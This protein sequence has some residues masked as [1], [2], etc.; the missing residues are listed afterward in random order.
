MD[1]KLSV[2]I[3]VYNVE[4]FLK[5]CLDSI[6]KQKIDGIEIILIDDGSSDNSA[7]LCK[8]Y[9]KEYSN[10]KFFSKKNGGASS[11]RNYGIPKASGEYIW[12]IDS[13]DK[14]ENNSIKQII[15][16]MNEFK[17]D[18]IICNSKKVYEDGEMIDECIYTIPKGEYTSHEF[19]DVLKGNPKSV[20]FAPQ[21]YI[22]KRSFI[23][24]NKF[25]F[26]EGIIHED[27]LWI[28]QLLI[29]AKNIFYSNLNIYYHYMWDGSVMHSTKIEKSGLSCYVVATNLLK[30]FDDSK[31][32]DLQ[33]LRDKNVNTYLQAVWKKSD[34][35][36]SN[37][38]N[39]IIPLKNAYY[40]KTKVKALLYF[41]SPKMYIKIH[42]FFGK[43]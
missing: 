32:D 20:I 38:V 29:S 26:Y 8:K 33:F 14:I 40:F 25:N 4:K 19:M 27:E 18:V 23:L 37:D 30:I 22:V 11:A 9:A 17:T 34:F 13:D 39:K 41:I 16:I 3:P 35:L 12:F 42:N 21:Y 7:E 10:V 5:R 28:P 24:E 1:I 36:K 31:R 2:I 15:E 6:L 43:I